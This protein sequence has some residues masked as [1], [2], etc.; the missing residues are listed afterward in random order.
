MHRILY[1]LLLTFVC[2]LSCDAQELR[3]VLMDA[4]HRK[5]VPHECLNVSLDSGQ[6]M[7][8]RTDDKGVATLLF[9]RN[10]SQPRPAQSLDSCNKTPTMLHLPADKLPDTVAILPNWYVACQ[11]ARPVAAV[12]NKQ[13]FDITDRLLHFSIAEILSRGVS[14][15]NTCTKFTAQAK[16]GELIF[17]AR[18]KTFLEGMR[19]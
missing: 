7:F 8:V 2:A 12:G 14:T 10:P 19:T 5:P 16:P 1:A 6:F 11:N 13:S 9:D 17:I 15:P 4:H 3:I 18:N